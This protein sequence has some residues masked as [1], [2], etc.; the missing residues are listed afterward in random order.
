MILDIFINIIFKDIN[1]IFKNF[2]KIIRKI[3]GLEIIRSEV[4]KNK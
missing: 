2:C 1:Q 3:G 4:E